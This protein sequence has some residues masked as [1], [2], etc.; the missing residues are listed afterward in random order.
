MTCTEIY[1]WM[2]NPSLLNKSTLLEL[3]QMIDDY[4][5]FHA[6]RMLYLKN[7]SLLQDI[8]FEK[9]VKKMSIFIPD[10]RML[11]LLITDWP[12]DET[13]KTDAVEN[14]LENA[15][16]VIEK[17]MPAEE[18][19]EKDFVSSFVSKPISP[20]AA[21]ADYAGWLARHA[22]D[23]PSEEGNDN[24]LKRQDLIDSFIAIEGHLLAQRLNQTVATKAPEPVA[25]GETAASIIPEGDALDDSYFTETLARVYISQKRYDKAL[26]II[27]VLSLKYPKKNL[28]FADQI[29]YLERIINFKK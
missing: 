5:Y 14:K 12:E 23:I 10:R 16:Q 22:D 29:R 11:Y 2:A 20:V 28:Y 18:L 24:R 19:D 6:A 27:R 1:E 13:K 4:P 8:R 25:E 9:E 26:E 7:L 15:L 17:V 21:T 3:R